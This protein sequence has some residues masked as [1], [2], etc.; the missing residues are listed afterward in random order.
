M[1]GKAPGAGGGL[2]VAAGQYPRFRRDP[3][4]GWEPRP[5]QGA[6]GGMGTC[7]ATTLRFQP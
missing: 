3:T 6:A 7:H 1:G 5:G 4:A 2:T